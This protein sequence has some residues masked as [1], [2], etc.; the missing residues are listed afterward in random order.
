MGPTPAPLPQAYGCTPTARSGQKTGKEK[1][2]KK[3]NGE[4]KLEIK[5]FGLYRSTCYRE[6]F[7]RICNSD[8]L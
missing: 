6:Q 4:I 7:L 2:G 8:M 5:T 1:T 3:E